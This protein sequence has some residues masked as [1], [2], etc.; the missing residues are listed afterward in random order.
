[1]KLFLST[2][3]VICFLLS[4][5]NSS[6]QIKQVKFNT[7]EGTNGVSV[8]K[9]IGITRD[10]YGFI[11]FADQSNGCIIRFDGSHMTRYRN[12]PKNPTSLGGSN[13][14]CIAVDSSGNLWIGFIGTGLDKFDP[15]TGIFTHFSHDTINKASLSADI[16]SALLVDH[17]G[18][19]WVG[20]LS[21]LDLLDQ[22][23]G[24]F[25]HYSHNEND[26]T[27]LSHNIVRSIYEDRSGELWLGTGGFFEPIKGGG[28]LNHFHRQSGTFTRYLS[29]S[30]NPKT[31]IDNRVKSIFEDS[32]GTFWI[33]T[34]GD[35][36]HTMDRKTGLFTRLRYNPKYPEQL[37]RPPVQNGLD[38]ITFITED[39]DKKIWIGTWANGLT[40]YD[41]LSGQIIRYGNKDDKTGVFKDNSSWCAYAAPDGIIWLSTENANESLYKIDIYNTIIPH[42]GNSRDDG[43]FTF[44]EESATVCWYGT[45]SGLVRKDFKNGTT[46]RFLNNPGDPNSLS[47]NRVR[48]ILKDKQGD[49]WIGTANGLNHFNPKTEKFTRYYNGADK[50]VFYSVWRLCE[51]SD[52]TIWVG[53]LGRG[54]EMLNKKTGKFTNYK[55]N[56]AEINLTNNIMISDLYRDEN[57]DLWIG[58]FN[59]VGLNKRNS[60]TGKFTRY[61]P[62]LSIGKIYRDAAGTLW[63]GAS[64]GLFKYD[65]KSDSFSALGDENSENYIT[66][67][68]GVTADKEDNLWVSTEKGI[69]MVTKKR[70]QVFLYGK[71]YV[72]PG[73]NFNFYAPSS[74]SRQDGELY[75]GTNNGY[76]AFYPEKLKAGFGKTPFYFTSFWLDNKEIRPGTEN[77]LKESLISTKEIRLNHNQNVFSISATFIDFRSVPGKKIY[78]QLENYDNDWRTAGAEDKIQYYKVPPGEYIFRIKTTNGSTGEWI[79]K[80]IHVIISH[81]WWRTWWA[82]L[83]YGLLLAVGAFAIHRFQKQR[84]LQAERKKAEA[85]ELAQA[86]E[87]EKAYTQLETA[88]ENLKSTQAQLIQSEKM[89]S[90]GELTAGIAHEIQN[91]LNFVNNFSEINTELS[92]ELSAAAQKGD[93]QEIIQ[94]AN[95]IRSNQ[96]KISEH[97]KRADAIVKGMLQHSRSGSGVKEPTNINALADEYLRL[98]YHGLRAKHKS[99]NATMKTDFDETIGTINIIPQDI[100]R[101]MLNLINNAFY[102]V[103]EKAKQNI[104]GYEPTVE[105]S[106]KKEGNKVLI[107]VK[108][109]GNGIPKKVLDKIF[110][111]FFTTKPT[112]Q[113]TGLGLSL[114]YDIVKAHGGELKVETKEGKGSA[115]MIILPSA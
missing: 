46:R 10:K 86:K 50:S 100:G 41:P 81:P 64:A 59:V 40:R 110:Q 67:V 112:G 42:F 16:V 35:G 89:A 106:T 39:A 11:W 24:T 92:D 63:V 62:G 26:S 93:L 37:S 98:A 32:R 105:V 111:P 74:F 91:P 78:Y 66:G 108:D 21:G 83:L 72:V 79:E 113:G 107:A 115:F 51:E 97:G 104:A 6:A 71:E 49:F 82:Y 43:V 76:Y 75:F 73:A 44:Y 53:T 31:L 36:L 48:D 13:P 23:T 69:Y 61:L 3:I 4:P 14:E 25:K 18:N 90:L 87:I 85:I 29:D 68:A 65:K 55:I 27:S 103:D 15:V 2:C 38:H 77:P 94:L 34:S 8:G 33:G 56:S 5:S 58:T 9:I 28:G 57:N 30:A 84:Y 7:V 114:S 1:M 17:L 101:V 102:V 22:K 88:H 80:S 95:D 45:D 52:S 20:T 60:R 109:N 12:D 70:D 47:N 99:F 19:V 96:E 54:L